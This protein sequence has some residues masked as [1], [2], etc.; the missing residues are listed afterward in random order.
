[1]RAWHVWRLRI[2]ALFRGS[3]VDRDDRDE[4]QAHLEYLAQEYIEQGLAPAEARMQALRDFGGLAQLEEASRDARG[5]R[6]VHDAIQ[7]GRYALRLL[8]RTPGFTLAA[9]LTLALGLG[10]NTA[11]FSLVDTVLLRTLPVRQPHELV[12]LQT[13]GSSGLAGVP[14]FPF[15]ERVRDHASSFSGLAAYAAD[16]LRVEVD[17]SVEQAYGQIAS[18]SYFELLGLR[19]AIGRL[20]TADDERLDP[21]VAVI[22]YGYWQR[23]FGGDPRA[24]G[25]SVTFGDRTYTIV[26][27]TP[28]AFWG[29]TP[30]RQIELTLPITQARD[31]LANVDAWGWY[32]AVGRLKSAA[33]VQTAAAEVDAALQAFIADT[34]QPSARRE[35][36][37]RATLLSAAQGSDGLR[38]RFGRPLVALTAIAAGVLLIACVNIANLLLA[39]GLTRSREFAM[40]VAA[41]A[42]A[43][44]L[45]RQAMAETLL[46]FALGGAAGLG[47]AYLAARTLAQFFAVGRNPIV[48]D[49][50]YDWRF[51]VFAAGVAVITGLATGLWPAL[52]SA[53]ADPQAAIR[54]GE[55]RL[56]GS[57][58]VAIAGRVLVTTQIA[59]S[60]VM[61]VTAVIF[62]RTIGNLRSV[63]VGFSGTHVLTMSVDVVLPAQEASAL[64]RQLWAR[65]LEE[66]R[67]IPGVQAASLSTLTPLS[68]RD[69]GRR[70]SVAGYQPRDERDR[71]IRLNHVSEDYFRTF[72]IE[73]TAGRAFTPR[74][75]A[76]A[77]KVAVINESAA[78]D[79]F[80]GRSPLGEMLDFGKPGAFQIVGVARDHKHQSL[81]QQVPRFAYVPIAQ[82]LDLLTRISLAVASGQPVGT[83]APVVAA[84]VRRVHPKTLV[85]DVIGV[86]EQ[87]DATLVS[88]RLLSTLATAFALLAVLLAAI[89]LYGVLGYS[90][91]RRR[92][93]FG[94]RLALGAPPRTLA[95]GVLR[96]MI[97][98]VA[99]GI[100]VGLAIAAATSRA[101]ASLLFGV[102]A[103]DIG[104]YAVSVA[105]LV[106]IAAIAAWLPARRASR[107]DPVIAL[108]AE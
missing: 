1:M 11:I 81:R 49:V 80:G 73:V 87:I 8:R 36:F 54:E 48:L 71:A 65:A 63:D 12:F 4:M 68:G 44:R 75:A 98:P 85:S 27:V 10:A 99:I 14:A 2:R 106:L 29:L 86:Q 59:L 66:V 74:D 70:V 38:Q 17:G 92:A 102:N 60:V 82:P 58:P 77:P 22:G 37:S 69:T 7:D 108:R 55:S 21:P 89:G 19:P 95:A 91:A 94:V 103:G 18:G 47:V 93:E 104:N 96:E 31:M 56:I 34:N 24:I 41:G 13:T 45:L 57:R 51:T 16:E 42:R 107:V 5:V 78:R 88:E 40:R 79:Y 50:H 67:R 6:W 62:V 35:R 20:F 25:R 9:V 30:G 52:R 23:R 76:G 97:P 33:L 100:G 83:L 64:R 72:G 84:A 105:A 61:M 43:G 101:A 46:L 53:R 28:P 26:G 3:R 39:R 15:F 32:S 90:V